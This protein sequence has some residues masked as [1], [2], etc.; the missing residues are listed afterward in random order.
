MGNAIVK[1]VKK[2]KKL[3]GFLKRRNLVLTD[4]EDEEPESIDIRKKGTREERVYRQEVVSRLDFQEDDNG[5][6]RLSDVLLVEN[7]KDNVKERSYGSVKK[8]PRRQRNRSYK[9][10]LALAEAIRLDS[11]K[12]RGGYSKIHLDGFSSQRIDRRRRVD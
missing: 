1:L 12:R 9:K 8:T 5:V 6:K 2:V 11:Y 3:E 4:L 10:K 7:K